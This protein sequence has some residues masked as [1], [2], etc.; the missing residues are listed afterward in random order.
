M[1]ATAADVSP[2]TVVGDMHTLCVLKGMWRPAGVIESLGMSQ[3]ILEVFR[4]TL[5]DACSRRRLERL[6]NRLSKIIGAARKSQHL[7]TRRKLAG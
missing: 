4:R 1:A 7:K 5:P 3:H 2:D 6:A